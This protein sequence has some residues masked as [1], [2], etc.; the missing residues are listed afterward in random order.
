MKAISKHGILITFFILY[1]WRPLVLGFY[2]DDWS[3]F[4]QRSVL[5]HQPFSLTRLLFYKTIHFERIGRSIPDFLTSSLFGNNPIL[6]QSCLALLTLLSAFTLKKLIDSLFKLLNI[7]NHHIGKMAAILWLSLPWLLGVT[8]WSASIPILLSGIL[9]MTGGYLIFNG[10][11]NKKTSVIIPS[12]LYLWCLLMYEQFYFQ[13]I[14]IIIFGFIAKIHKKINWKALF[15][16]FL[17]LSIAQIIALYWNRYVALLAHTVKPIYSNW[18]G[19]FI[20]NLLSFYPKVISES[21]NE[22]KRFLLPLFIIFFLII[23]FSIIKNLFNKENRKT[24]GFQLILLIIG[25]LGLSLSIFVFSIVGYDF[26]GIGMISRTTLAVS[27]WLILTIS[28]LISIINIKPPLFLKKISLILYF[29][30]LF[31]LSCSS[32]L[33][34]MDWANAWK[35]QQNIIDQV[36]IEKIIATGK[37]PVILYIAP[38]TFNE[39]NIFLGIIDF[40]SALLNKYPEIPEGKVFIPHI[41]RIYPEYYTF[42]KTKISFCYN[43]WDGE[44]VTYNSDPYVKTNEVY[45]WNYFTKEFTKMNYPFKIENGE[46]TKL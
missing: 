24:L 1:L 28:I 46:I 5:N 16:P 27:F 20:G 25:I 14:F 31:I 12:F 45:L 29:L 7:E 11:L 38:N 8:V 19:V 33:R 4:T 17:G 35:T 32:F 44:T 36:P 34:T 43:I 13:F 6:W 30:F 41:P 37:K 26:L 10:W 18:L 9:F 42:G 22:L 23:I 40:T 21:N 2:A 39:V 3:I 15:L